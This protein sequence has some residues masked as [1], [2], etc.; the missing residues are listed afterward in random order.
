MKAQLQQVII[1][2]NGCKV[3]IH[4]IIILGI[5]LPFIHQAHGWRCCNNTWWGT[6]LD[7]SEFLLHWRDIYQKALLSCLFKFQCLPTLQLLFLCQLKLASVWLYLYQVRW[8]KVME[9][10][11]PVNKFMSMRGINRMR[12]IFSWQI[13]FWH[14]VGLYFGCKVFVYSPCLDETLPTLVGNILLIIWSCWVLH[15][16]WTTFMSGYLLRILFI[17][18][19]IFPK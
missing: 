3:I 17:A 16:P 10:S 2:I 9:G 13:L 1:T 18:S 4:T 19:C 8:I 6:I 12:Y 7:K 5:L 11:S 15:A 14:A